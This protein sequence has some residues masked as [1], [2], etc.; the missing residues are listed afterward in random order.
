[1]RRRTV[2]VR[3]NARIPDATERMFR[4]PD[5]SGIGYTQFVQENRAL[6][7]KHL[8]TMI[9]FWLSTGAEPFTLRRRSGFDDWSAKVGGV[10]QACG[11]DGFLDNFEAVSV[12]L[13]GAAYRQFVTQ[14]YKRYNAGNVQTANALFDWATDL[15]LSILTGSNEDQK[16]TRFM[17]SSLVSMIDRTYAIGDGDFMFQQTMDSEQNIGFQLVEV[18]SGNTEVKA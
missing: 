12:D 14:F 17:K 3:L 9:Q 13:D 5:E 7:I 6:A 4:H 10:L 2:F 8:L 18:A 1:M 16:R 11:V 15:Q